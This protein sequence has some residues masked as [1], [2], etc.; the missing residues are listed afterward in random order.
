[1]QSHT[2][3]F[4]IYVKQEGADEEMGNVRNSLTVGSDGGEY[5]V[6]FK[7]N[8]N[9]FAIADQDWVSA[10][11]DSYGENMHISVFQMPEDFEGEQRTATISLYREGNYGDSSKIPFHTIEVTQMNQ[12]F[13]I[14]FTCTDDYPPIYPDHFDAEVLAVYCQDGKGYVDFGGP[15]NIADGQFYY[16]QTITSIKLPDC[17]TSIGESAFY[18]CDALETVELPETI[19]SIG[20]SAF[21]NCDN[22][23]SIVLPSRGLRDIGNSAF[24][25]CKSLEYV[26]LGEG[27]ENIGRLA[28][29][30]CEKFRVIH[31][32]NTVRTVGERAFCGCPNLASFT[33]NLT[34]EDGRCI[35]I[36]NEIKAYAP[37]DNGRHYDIPAGIKS[38]GSYAFA[39]LDDLF[40]V[41]LGDDVEEIKDHAFYYSAL[42]NDRIGVN[43]K[44]VKVIG[45]YAFAETNLKMVEIPD[46]TTKLGKYAFHG[47]TFLRDLN[48]GEGLTEIEEGTFSMTAISSF[49]IP[50]N[51]TRIGA[52]AF[53]DCLSFFKA[54]TIHR[55]VTYIGTEAFYTPHLNYAYVIGPEPASAE[56]GE[57]V[58]HENTTVEVPFDYEYL[59]RN[60]PDWAQYDPKDWIPDDVENQE[61]E[62]DFIP[63]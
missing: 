15:I 41:G 28:F 2:A 43:L 27:L 52:Y 18:D 33:G 39:Y 8:V 7:T 30:G 58:F 54:V 9:Y 19:T 21:A 49:R 63:G 48:F 57:R 5:Q 40:Y 44:N 53:K 47:C 16:E 50:K 23:K 42:D 35:V 34:T 46:C 55:Y 56:L 61:P 1:M 25:L 13:R 14:E 11:A 26:K 24:S 60:D 51:I 17:V 31:I 32:P 22:L 29:Y 20:A 45:D 12:S 62:Q 4:E 10:G 3:S 36:D 37:G 6:E 59:Y 38:V